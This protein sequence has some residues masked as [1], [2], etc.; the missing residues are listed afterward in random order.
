M[1]AMLLSNV[2]VGVLECLFKRSRNDAQMAE[3]ASGAALQISTETV[4]SREGCVETRS[5]I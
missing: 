1:K 4:G 3:P 5:N 2:C